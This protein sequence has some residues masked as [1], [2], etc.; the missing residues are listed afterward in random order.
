MKAEAVEW[1][2]A[3][4]RGGFASGTSDLVRRRRY[5][6]LLLAA[7]TPPTGRIT[8]VNGL[9]AW[10]D[11]PDGRYALSSQLYAPDVVHP[12][13]QRYIASFDNDPWPRWTFALP[14]G[15]VIEHEL[16]VVP[17][18]AITALSWRL[19]SP[20]PD[21][22]LSIRPLLSG[23]DYHA[24]HHE[25]GAFRFDAAV[26]GDRVTWTPYDGIPSIVATSNGNYT[27]GPEWYRRFL[28]SE[29]QIRGLDAVE[30]LASP[31]V[32]AWNL[33]SPA[34]L[35]LRAST[36]GASLHQPDGALE[37]FESRRARERNRRGFAS[38][39]HRGADAYLVSRGSGKT[40]VAGYPWFTDWG[41]DTFSAMRG[42]C[43]A[44]GRLQEAGEILLA[45]SG[46]VSE[47]MLPNRFPDRG[48]AP[49][50]NSVDASLWF[51]IAVGDYLAACEDSGIALPEREVAT[52]RTAVESIVEGYAAGPR[53]GIR[54]DGDGLL[55][56]GGPGV[57]LTWMDAK[58]G[59]WVVTPRTGKPVE[60][61]A[62]WLNALAICARWTHR[63]EAALQAGTT[64]F[65]A[66]FWDGSLGHLYDVVDVDHQ[67]GKVDAT[68]R[69][70]Q[71]FAVGGL[72]LML[73]ERAV[74]RRIVDALEAKLLTPMGLRSLTPD[75]PDYA[76]RYEGGPA[77]RD[78]RYH[79]GT[80]W[81]WLLGPFVEAWIRV[82]GSSVRLRTEAVKR[83]LEPLLLLADSTGGHLPEIADGDAP[84]HA[85][86]CPAQ[87]WSLGELLRLRETVL[88]RG[89]ARQRAP[90]PSLAQAV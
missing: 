35:L 85:R 32:F 52:L 36:A 50:F 57:Q 69:P 74:G 89:R 21:V 62:L 51:V 27:P 64:S 67:P 12:D 66:R 48:D 11:T 10:L 55:A 56:G 14:G 53:F 22:T 87:A 68:L 3:D 24:T 19:R 28:Y 16:F 58:I 72:P 40:L 8:L 37:Q 49:E 70:N 23:R 45:W 34:V 25:N 90:R 26:A 39:L 33:S 13:G 78:A 41:R 63:W 1:L 65:R 76:G 31:G 17:G 54:L 44:T 81:P 60:V 42:L 46:A 5:H 6:S 38:V 61:Q 7:T 9:E 4:G 47:G 82:H 73:V 15:I 84:H 29:E 30:D 86:G 75:S 43:I 2:E 83:F 18:D 80:A 77:E 88:G 59:D 79:R 20:R 71:I